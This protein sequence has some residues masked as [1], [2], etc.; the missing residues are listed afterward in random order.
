MVI[1]MRAN[2]VRPSGRVGVRSHR[3]D[4]NRVTAA[5]ESAGVATGQPA[6]I[7]SPGIQDH[8]ATTA[9]MNAPK[10]GY[11]TAS[12]NLLTGHPGP[13]LVPTLVVTEVS[14]LVGSRLGAYAE[15]QFIRDFAV[16][17]LQA[18]PMVPD[19]WPRIA[20]LVN[21]YRDLPLGTVDAS[22]VATSERLGVT[23]VATTD[24]RHFSVVK[25]THCHRLNI[26]PSPALPLHEAQP[27]NP[28]LEGTL[29]SATTRSLRRLAH[30]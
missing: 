11:R 23:T 30:D 21:E 18:E 12:L 20:E 5:S 17:N 7:C 25:P 16:G 14:Y 19:D 1:D 8:I 22:V 13:L 26:I 24:K 10:G 4:P 2:T 29:H 6:S 27:E 15:V 28:P 9:E 3:G